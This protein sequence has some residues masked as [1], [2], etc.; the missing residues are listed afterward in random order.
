MTYKFERIGEPRVC[1]EVNGPPRPGPK[2]VVIIGVPRGGTS[3]VAAVVDA[4]GVYLGPPEEMGRWQ[5]EDQTMQSGDVDTLRACVAARNLQY[6]IW[7]WKNAGGAVL[8]RDLLPDLRNPHVI[9][10]HR[11]AVATI[12]GI[13]RADERYGD[14]VLPIAE[15]VT[16]VAEWNRHNWNV[17]LDAGVPTLLVSYERAMLGRLGLLL[18]VCDFLKLSPGQRQWCEALARISPTGGYLALDGESAHV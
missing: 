9:I 12:D 7:G 2:T 10:V 14:R 17:A 11:D 8:L 3:M 6:D 4:L 18:S 13:M 5:F 15:Y 16:A 1:L